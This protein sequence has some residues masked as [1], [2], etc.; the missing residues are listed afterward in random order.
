MLSKPVS[1]PLDIRLRIGSVQ[2]KK[3]QLERK[4]KKLDFNEEKLFPHS[5]FYQ[6]KRKFF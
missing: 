5:D 4:Y 2:V 1:T 3:Y 6:K